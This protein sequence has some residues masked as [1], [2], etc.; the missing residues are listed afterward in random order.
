FEDPADLARIAANRAAIATGALLWTLNNVDL[1]FIA[2]FAW[3][4]LHPVAPFMARAYL[5][6]RV[7]ESGVMMFGVM[8]LVT[9]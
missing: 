9:I 2:L 1:V 4:V 3:P 5:T 6:T 7:I 8:A